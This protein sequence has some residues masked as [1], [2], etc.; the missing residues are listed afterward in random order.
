MKYLPAAA[1]MEANNGLHKQRHKTISLSIHI[2]V[3]TSFARDI[4]VNRHPQRHEGI[5][6]KSRIFL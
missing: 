2:S 5:N 6:R 3:D 4:N 1:L